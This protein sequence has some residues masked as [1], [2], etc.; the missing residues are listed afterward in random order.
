LSYFT[1]KERKLNLFITYKLSIYVP[2]PFYACDLYYYLGVI[3]IIIWEM[4][5]SALFIF[6]KMQVIIVLKI[7]IKYLGA[8]A[9]F[10]MLNV[11]REH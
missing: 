8:I 5:I 11:S 9:Y 6:F 3:Y 7:K 4:L 1:T 2:P 10:R